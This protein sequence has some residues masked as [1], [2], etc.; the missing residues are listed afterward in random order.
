M[1]ERWS[2]ARSIDRPSTS[3]TV[4]GVI[5]LFFFI[6]FV[7]YWILFRNFSNFHWNIFA[8]EK[9]IYRII[10][11]L[12]TASSTI[13]TKSCTHK[14]NECTVFIGQNQLNWLHENMCIT[15]I[16]LFDEKKNKLANVESWAWSNH[17]CV[18]N[19]HVQLLC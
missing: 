17:K 16:W 2:C 18:P 7:F 4:S 1:F 10:I 6:I 3:I 11:N 14:S 8:K 15:L 12:L 9:K 13:V 19:I 5:R